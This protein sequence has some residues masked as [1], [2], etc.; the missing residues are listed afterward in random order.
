MVQYISCGL[1]ED[2]VRLLKIR[3]NLSTTIGTRLPTAHARLPIGY[4]K[5]PLRYKCVVSLMGCKT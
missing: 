4:P 5:L 1:R 2:A 3:D